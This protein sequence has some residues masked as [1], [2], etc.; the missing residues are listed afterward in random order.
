MAKAN[1]ISSLYWLKGICAFLVV[2]CHA[3]LFG[4]YGDYLLAPFK[5]SAVPFFFVISGYFLYSSDRNKFYG[6][7]LGSL[8]KIVP[9][10]IICNLVYY[11][12][13]L[14]S[15]GSMIKSWGQVVDLLLYGRSI[16]LQLWYLSAFMWGVVFF[17]AYLKWVAPKLSSPERVYYYLLP[18]SLLSVFGIGYK[19]WTATTFGLEY[20]ALNA[21]A[22]ALP[23][24]SLGFI[25]SRYEQKLLNWIKLPYVLMGLL[26][27]QA[28]T[29]SAWWQRG[30]VAYGPFFMTMP[31]VAVTF[32]YLLKF[33][34][35]GQGTWLEKVGR[36]YSANIYYWHMLM[37]TVG[38]YLMRFVG[39]EQYFDTVAVL[40][41]FSLSYMVAVVI[42]RVQG[43]LGVRV[44]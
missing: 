34:G 25:F 6:R 20:F 37:L 36:Q 27:L 11:L 3:P 4:V 22:Y 2:C 24:L 9:I 43:R 31:F 18:L 26:L 8:K 7:L 13:F 21:V 30:S 35:W 28:E 44:L 39:L 42:D 29:Y 14:P 41:A 33:K 17:M 23:Y 10:I 38:R 15:R 1:V 5:T 32:L 40:V 19:D 12:W 16:L